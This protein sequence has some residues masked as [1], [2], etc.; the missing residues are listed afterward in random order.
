MSNRKK[1]GIIPV[2][3]ILGLPPSI[4]VSVFSLKREIIVITTYKDYGGD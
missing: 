4:S 3:Q 2:V 1:L